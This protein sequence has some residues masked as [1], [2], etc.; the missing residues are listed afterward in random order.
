MA[1]HH[2]PASTAAEE[3][4]QSGM[5]MEGYDIVGYQAAIGAPGSA[6]D[7]V[8]RIFRG[9]GPIDVG[10]GFHLPHY[11]LMV[12]ETGGWE[13]SSQNGGSHKF[14]DL[15]SALSALE[16]HVITDALTRR[17]DLFHL[18]GAALCLPTRRAGI[19]LAGDSR[20]GKTTAALALML[21]GFVPFA[22]DVALVDPE[23]LELRTLRRA[24]HVD[25]GTWSI[26]EHLNGPLG[27]NDE[28]PPGYFLPPQWAEQ[29]VPLRW[30]LFLDLR[31]DREPQLIP[32]STAEA[33]TAILAQTLNLRNATKLALRT[34][35][36]LTQRVACFRFLTGDLPSS[37]AMIQQLVAAS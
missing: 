20:S 14:P 22:D 5:R 6:Y 8:R 1:L 23:G 29:P 18:H 15:P 36:Q 10:T 3:N 13:M 2:S 11:M 35:N 7:S 16:W 31:P 25:A 33:A 17:D 27:R 34:V 30:L 28:D 4:D 32:M 21:R 26:L 37:V 19:A 9:F 12:P 24:F